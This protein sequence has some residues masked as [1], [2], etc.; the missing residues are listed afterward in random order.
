MSEAG[1]IETPM[2][3][4]CEEVVTSSTGVCG[5][6]ESTDLKATEL[7]SLPSLPDPNVTPEEEREDFVNHGLAR[8]EASRHDWSTKKHVLDSKEVTT[9]PLDG[10]LDAIFTWPRDFPQAV[11]WSQMV[12]ILQDLWEAEVGL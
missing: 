5:V 2:N 6:V 8:W 1:N 4:K 3:Y 11:P 7:T 10:I 9:R 12:D